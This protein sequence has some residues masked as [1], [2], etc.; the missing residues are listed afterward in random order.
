[1]EIN[2][3][4]VDRPKFDDLKDED[5]FEDFSRKDEEE[6]NEEKLI[7]WKREMTDSHEIIQRSKT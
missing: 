7:K 3:Q 5:S 4:I 2:S 6:E 1:M